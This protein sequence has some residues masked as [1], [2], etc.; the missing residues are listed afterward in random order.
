MDKF[1]NEM[2]TK[3]KE[4]WKVIGIVVLV[5]LAAIFGDSSGV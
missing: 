3:V 1:M 5:V 4:N 2:V